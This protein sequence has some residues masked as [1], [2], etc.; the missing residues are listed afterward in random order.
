MIH[1]QS[2]DYKADGYDIKYVWKTFAK[3]KPQK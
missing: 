3:I 1:H 2:A